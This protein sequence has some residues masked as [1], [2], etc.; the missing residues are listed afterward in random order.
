MLFALAVA[1]F[2]ARAAADGSNDTL[3]SSLRVRPQTEPD[4]AAIRGGLVLFGASY[5]VCAGGAAA[6]D[7]EG[8]TGWLL[9]P[10]A[11]PFIALAERAEANSWALAMAGVAQG[12]GSALVVYGFVHPRRVMGTP[13]SRRVGLRV[14]WS[15]VQLVGR[16]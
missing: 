7:F 16:F 15:T 3:P 1:L 8:R 10:V 4:V 11:G 2:N 6:Q 14:G 12:A 9:V 13:T 5:A